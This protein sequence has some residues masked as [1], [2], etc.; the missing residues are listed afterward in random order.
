MKCLSLGVMFQCRFIV[1]RFFNVYFFTCQ[2]Y[3]SF[4]YVSKPSSATGRTG[5]RPGKSMFHCGVSTKFQSHHQLQDAWDIGLLKLMMMSLKFSRNA[6]VTGAL[7]GRCPVRPAADGD[8][9]ISIV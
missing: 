5:R 3:E 9:E 6:Q 7:T 8:F 4:Y 2:T 1:F